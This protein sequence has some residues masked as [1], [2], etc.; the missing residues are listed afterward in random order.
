M[1]N[2]FELKQYCK[3]GHLFDDDNTY[4]RKNGNRR[5]RKC[6]SLRRTPFYKRPSSHADTQ[7]RFWAFVKKGTPEECWEWTGYRHEEGYGV[8]TVNSKQKKAHRLTWEFVFS[9]IPDGLE[10]CHKCDNPPCC[11]PSHLFLGT[12][13]DNISDMINKGRASWQKSKKQRE[14]SR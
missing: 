6:D 5:C 1:T 2:H 8:F 4:I 9:P 7:T 14:E 13:V 12:H 10:V 11:N 3:R